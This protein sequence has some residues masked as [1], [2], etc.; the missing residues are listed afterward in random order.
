MAILLSSKSIY[1]GFVT[2]NYRTIKDI[3]RQ[4]LG[5]RDYAE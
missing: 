2:L 4:S 3:P 5:T 1:E